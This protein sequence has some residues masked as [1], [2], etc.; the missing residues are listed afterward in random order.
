VISE[1]VVQVLW[2]IGAVV[3]AGLF[4]YLGLALWRAEDL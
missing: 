1:A 2:W 4:V 3:S